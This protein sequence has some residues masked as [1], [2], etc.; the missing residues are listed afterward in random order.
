[1][2]IMRQAGKSLLMSWLLL[3]L[4]I[5]I[6]LDGGQRASADS[7]SFAFADPNSQAIV[8][9]FEYVR[10]HIFLRLDLDG[11]GPSTIMLDTGFVSDERMILVD[12]SVAGRLRLHRGEKMDVDGMGAND[13]LARK[14]HDIDIH[15][16]PNVVVHSSAEEINLSM[17]S[18][19]LDHPLDGILGF[20][21]LRDYV[22]DIDYTHGVL[23]LYPPQHYHYHGD[24]IQLRMDK[25]SPVIQVKVVLPDGKERWTQLLIDTGSDSEILFYRQ[26]VVKYAHS[27]MS[28]DKREITYIGLGG[29]YTCD[30][31]QIRNIQFGD[32]ALGDSLIFN[33]PYVDLARMT[34]GASAKSHLDGHVGNPLLQHANAI[35]DPSRRRF[36]IEPIQKAAMAKVAVN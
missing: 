27:L 9:P 26:F 13:V 25:T 10:G 11:A 30:V 6:A 7:Y 19:A 35:F 36:I 18:H 29:T 32:V 31:V 14:I 12:S 21:F 28:R 23:R 16:N 17:L 2:P 8:I 34:A 5:G 15:L 3:F 24:G 22:T 20:A 4:T 33:S 1:M